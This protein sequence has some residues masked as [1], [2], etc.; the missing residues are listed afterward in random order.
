MK[1]LESQ[2]QQ[3][4]IRIFRIRWRKY[5]NRLFAI[6]NG[7]KRNPITAHFLKMEGVMAGVPD[8]F[9]SIPKGSYGGLFIEMKAATG[10]LTPYQQAFIKEH[11]GD[12]KCV[13][14]RS[15]NQFLEAV[16]AY[17]NEPE[18]KRA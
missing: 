8:L 15:V 13:V 9:L 12:Y 11:E 6:P 14:C 17:L 18:I 10:N 4:C 16:E 2:L 3:S 5:E 7:G 1:T